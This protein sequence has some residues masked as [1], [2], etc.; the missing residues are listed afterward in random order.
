MKKLTLFL[1]KSNKITSLRGA[2]NFTS[3]YIPKRAEIREP[4]YSGAKMIPRKL[5]AHCDEALNSSEGAVSH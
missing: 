3:E 2:S 1:K 5:K 4:F